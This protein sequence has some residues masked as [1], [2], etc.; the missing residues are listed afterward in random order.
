MTASQAG[1]AHTIGAPLVTTNSLP[2]LA[3]LGL[4]QPGPDRSARTDRRGR[5]KPGVPELAKAVSRSRAGGAGAGGGKFEAGWAAVSPVSPVPPA[6]G[7]PNGSIPLPGVGERR[8]A[9]T[10]T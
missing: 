9:G 6:T 8:V 5:A 7:F 1:L 2:K 4:T 3:G 10:G